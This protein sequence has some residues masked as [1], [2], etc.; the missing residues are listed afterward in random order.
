[1][2]NWFKLVFFHRAKFIIFDNGLMKAMGYWSDLTLFLHHSSIATFLLVITAEGWISAPLTVQTFEHRLTWWVSPPKH[3]AFVMKACINVILRLLY[4]VAVSCCTNKKGQRRTL[5][6]NML[7]D[8][9]IIFHPLPSL[10][11]DVSNVLVQIKQKRGIACWAGG[12]S[13]FCLWLHL[14]YLYT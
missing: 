1:M 2:K 6:I 3:N 13:F 5:D 4:T 11:C 8:I 10:E 7:S 14:P 12:L 9:L